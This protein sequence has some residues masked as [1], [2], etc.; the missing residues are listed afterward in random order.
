MIKLDFNL[1]EISSP[2][3]YQVNYNAARNEWVENPDLPYPITI[4]LSKEA[5]GN[6]QIY[7]LIDKPHYKQSDFHSLGLFLDVDVT[8][9]EGK[10]QRE[11]AKALGCESEFAKIEL[12]WEQNNDAN[13]FNR[14]LIPLFAKHGLTK[15][16]ARRI[17]EHIKL[18]PWAD[19]LLKLNV[20]TYLVSSRP[21]YYIHRLAAKFGIP[22]QNTLCSEYIFN[23]NTHLISGCNP[24]SP[25]TKSTF[26][27]QKVI[28]HLFTIG[29]GDNQRD[30]QPFLMMVT[31]PIMIRKK[32]SDNILIDEFVTAPSHDS[33]INLIA[34]ISRQFSNGKT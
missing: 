33:I 4:D 12:G 2:A 11:Y 5:K 24:V 10:I 30:D 9:T 17:A 7:N 18:Q 14:Q 15:H 26:T 1:D 19:K 31:L 28:N 16:R 32:G 13:A 23:E 34:S 25:Q 20:T 27:R 29:V 6:R 21:S 8:L 22:P 3:I